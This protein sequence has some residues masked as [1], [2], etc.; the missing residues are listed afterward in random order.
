MTELINRVLL[1]FLAVEP[2]TVGLLLLPTI[3]ESQKMT[4]SRIDTIIKINS[5]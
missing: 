4:K 1:G 2:D 5:Q 3:G